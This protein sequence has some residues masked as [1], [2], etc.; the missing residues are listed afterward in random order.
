MAYPKFNSILLEKDKEEPKI[1]Y[2]TLNR[3]DKNNAISIGEEEMTGDIKK[4][5][6]EINH[7]DDCNVVIFKGA[8]K[9]FCA[10]FDLSMV[11]R[12]YG[13]EKGFKPSQRIRL[14]TDQDQLY[15]FTQ[16]ILDCNKVVITQVHGWAI[17]AGLYIVKASDIVVAADNSKFS[18]MGQR[19]AFGG[20]PTLPIELL[21]GHTK[22]VEEI[23]LTG[24]TIS[25]VEAEEAGYCTKAVPEADLESEVHNLAAA[26]SLLPRDCV[27]MGKF[28]RRHML[29]RLGVHSL[30]E[31]IL[32]H[33]FS[34]N[35]KYSDDEKELMFI[36][37][38]E[39]MGER[40]AFHKMHEKYEER[41][42]K[43]KYFRSYRPE[44]KG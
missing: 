17:E 21:M 33:T 14:Q 2:L 5:M 39:T 40:A 43:T 36:R 34:T 7:D 30:K 35:L 20:L 41:L 38:R 37:D 44:K 31:V 26:I 6:W 12:I 10:G 25:G 13:G 8:G 15:G 18:Q 3:P 19:L 11:Y 32:Y 23:L 27:V 42:N 22:K 29:E 28:A 4:A 16:A 1:T 9:N 24:R